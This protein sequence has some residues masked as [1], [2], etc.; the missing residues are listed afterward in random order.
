MLS[1]IHRTDGARRA[2]GK[3]LHPTE[4]PKAPVGNLLA[5]IPDAFWLRRADAFSF[6]RRQSALTNSVLSVK[7]KTLALRRTGA[8]VGSA[9]LE[10]NHFRRRTMAG[11]TVQQLKADID[12]GKTGDKNAEGFDLGLSTLGTDDEAAGTPNTA[13]QIAEARKLERARPRQPET[14]T[15]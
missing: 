6:R 15:T 14:S 9:E 13:Q 2:P 8:A 1:S 12:N 4:T 3:C 7:Y 10:N 5:F 11:P